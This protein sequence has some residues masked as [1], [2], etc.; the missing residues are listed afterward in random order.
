MATARGDRRGLRGH[1][2]HRDRHRC[3]NAEHGHQP[4]HLQHL[5][6]ARVLADGPGLDAQ[7]PGVYAQRPGVYAPGQ[8]T[9]AQGQAQHATAIAQAKATSDYAARNAALSQTYQSKEA[10]LAA[11]QQTANQEAATL[12]QELGQVQ[13]NSISAGGV[14]VVGQD[15]KSGT[16]HTNGDNGVGGSAC[17][18]ATLNDNSGSI[19]SIANNNNFDGPETVDVSGLDAL[20]IN[21]PCTW[22]LVP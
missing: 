1:A 20:Q 10:A 9:T 14:Y 13:A 18:F 7:R 2:G 5:A 22:N 19:N 3:R 21:G 12:K 15:I 8:L 11:T 4:G 6:G 17:Y 16:W